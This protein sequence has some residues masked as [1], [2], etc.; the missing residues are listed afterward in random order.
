MKSPSTFCTRCDRLPPHDRSECSAKDAICHNCSKRGYFKS[1]CKSA[2][3]VGNVYHHDLLDE[4]SSDDVT[5]KFIGVVN[6]QSSSA[7]T[8]SLLMNDHKVEIRELM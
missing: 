5:S 1:L 3:N 8:V 2:R 4:D 6:A 7:W